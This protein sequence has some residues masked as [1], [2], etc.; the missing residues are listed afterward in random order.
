MLRKAKER[1]ETKNV[2]LHAM[3]RLLC[4]RDCA[5]VWAC[6]CEI[7]WV[8]VVRAFGVQC[9]RV[10]SLKPKLRRTLQIMGDVQHQTR[11]PRFGLMWL[12]LRRIFGSICI[13]PAVR[14]QAGNKRW[15]AWL[16]GF[17]VCRRGKN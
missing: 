4:G 13:S 1:L 17:S 9:G 11:L 8:C 12:F 16:L 10:T 5:P 2:C 14:Q 15:S 7:V 6:V 3:V